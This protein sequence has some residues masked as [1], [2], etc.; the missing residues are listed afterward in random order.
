MDIHYVNRYVCCTCRA[1][2]QFVRAKC[3]LN[4]K[5]DDGYAAIH[6][7]ALNDHLDVVTALAELVSILF[8]VL[9]NAEY[10][11]SQVQAPSSKAIFCAHI[12]VKI[13]YIKNIGEPGDE[14]RFNT[15]DH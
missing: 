6:L 15:H 14:A 2:E 3:D 7:A 4:L 13:T 12:K 5:K 1:I 10:V 8:L 9:L 11:H